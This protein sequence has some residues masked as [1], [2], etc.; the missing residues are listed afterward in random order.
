M[1]PSLLRSGPPHPARHWAERPAARLA[2]WLCLLS[3]VLLAAVGCGER[4]PHSVDYAEVSGKVLYKGN[5]VPGGRV[6]FITPKWGFSGIADIDE[7]GQYKGMS[8][9][10]DVLIGVDNWMLRPPKVE[11]GKKPPPKVPSLKVPGEETRPPLK[12]KYVPIPAK[13]ADP[14]K[15][16]LTFKV[17]KGTQ[18]HDI[19]LD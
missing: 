11:K 6:T 5:P 15:S 13:Y 14:S 9:V 3:G 19:T 17:E 8:P 12:G 18:T 2:C 1:A 4:P 10:G 16:G 7:N